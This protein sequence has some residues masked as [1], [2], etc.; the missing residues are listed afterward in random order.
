MKTGT[1]I[2]SISSV[3]GI[4]AGGYLGTLPIYESLSAHQITPESAGI[5]L[6]TTGIIVGI[7]C[8]IAATIFNRVWQ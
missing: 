5:Y 2:G 1:V 3:L 8:A 7:S 4:I 6:A